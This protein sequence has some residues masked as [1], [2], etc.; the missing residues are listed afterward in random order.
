V[1]TCFFKHFLDAFKPSQACGVVADSISP[2]HPGAVLKQARQHAYSVDK[3]QVQCHNRR[4]FITEPSLES[5]P[6]RPLSTPQTDAG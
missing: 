4:L 2:R 3:S 1:N 5:S 6:S